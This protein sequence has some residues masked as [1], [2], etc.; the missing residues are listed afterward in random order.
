MHG[1]APKESGNISWDLKT[2][3]ESEGNMQ[4]SYRMSAFLTIGSPGLHRA[5][6]NSYLPTKV[7]TK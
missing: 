3:R 1:G 7:G 2:E 6:C 5:P 4:L